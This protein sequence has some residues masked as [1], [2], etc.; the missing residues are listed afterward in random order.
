MAS[1]KHSTHSVTIEAPFDVAW[2]YIS[3]WRTQPEWAT[4]FVK[5]IRQEGEQIYM[6]THTPEGEIPIQWVTN[7]E[8]GTIDIIFPNNSLTPTRL[9]QVDESLL[10]TFS[11]G[12]P[13]D[14]PDEIFRQGQSNMDKELAN[15]KQIIEN[16]I[17]V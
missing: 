4:R 7:R 17:A 11:F 9:S 3:D 12:M 14:T 6:D 16:R 10:Y 1:L 2:D 8:L 15:L 5:A 13:S